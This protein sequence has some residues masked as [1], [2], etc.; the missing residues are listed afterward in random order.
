[1]DQIDEEQDNNFKISAQKRALEAE[2]SD[3]KSN[4]E[5]LESS[6][7]SVSH[8]KTDFVFALELSALPYF[9]DLSI[10]RIMN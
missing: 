5:L 2:L 4:I 9:V 7:K 10:S 6:I 8:Y 3:V 1:M